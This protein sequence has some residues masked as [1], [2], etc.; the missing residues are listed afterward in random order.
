MLKVDTVLKTIRND[1]RRQTIPEEVYEVHPMVVKI[2]YPG[3]D[4]RSKDAGGFG[5]T[6]G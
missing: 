1:K 4:N 3:L 2:E 5:V 6:T